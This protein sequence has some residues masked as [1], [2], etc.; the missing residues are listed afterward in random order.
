MSGGMEG[1]RRMGM[2][3]VLEQRLLTVKEAAERLGVTPGRVRQF[4]VE[5]RLKGEKVGNVWVFT[6]DEIARFSEEP[7]RPGPKKKKSD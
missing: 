6:E 5:G 7:R 1:P 4:I 2:A 3:T